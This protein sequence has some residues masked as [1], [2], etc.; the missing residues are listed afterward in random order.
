MRII[1]SSAQMADHVC[2]MRDTMN[3]LSSKIYSCDV[4]CEGRIIIRLHIS[5][6]YMIT[7]ICECL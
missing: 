5:Y 2:C 6:V 3:Q 4:S 7:C 1:L